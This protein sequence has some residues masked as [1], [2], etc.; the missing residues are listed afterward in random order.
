MSE[1][2]IFSIS[3]TASDLAKKLKQAKCDELLGKTNTKISITILANFSTQYLV[4]SIFTSMVFDGVSPDIY[5]SSFDQ[6]EFEL[7]N[8]NSETYQ[9]NSDYVI[10]ALSSSR[11][12]IERGRVIHELAENIKQLI[13]QYKAKCNGDFIIVLPESMREGFDQTSFFAEYVRAIRTEFREKLQDIAY[14]IDIDPLIMEY[15]FDKWH[16]P[17]FYIT[18]KLSCHPNCY[19]LFG[20][21]ISS[22]ILSLIRRPIRLI[23]VDFD[24]TLWGGVVGDIGWENV[25]L[26]KDSIGFSHLLFQ[27]YLLHLKESGTILATSSKNSI[28]NVKE[29]FDKRKEM[30]LKFED[31]VTHKINWEPK[32]QNIFDI[33]QELNLTSTGVMFIDDS[34]FEREEVKAHFPE[35]VV[36]ELPEHVEHWCEFLSKSGY[37][38]VAKKSNNDLERSDMYLAEKKRKEA[39]SKHGDYADFLRELNLELFPQKVTEKNFDRVFELIHKTNQFNLNARRLTRVELANFASNEEC[40]C[41]CYSLKDK[42]SDYGIISAL[43]V[44]R[45][46]ANWLIHNWIMS[47]RA[48][49]R[50]V[51]NSV[52]DHF[53]ET[54][55]GEGETVLG[56]YVETDKN[57]PVIDL[58]PRIGFHQS[59]A[60]NVYS[61][62]A[63]N[64]KNTK[65]EHIQCISENVLK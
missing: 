19:P 7:N 33:L 64:A 17:K 55:I 4:N 50:G 24:N 28:E 59:P 51:E 21:Y 18:A 34:K 62:T 39:A 16:S 43:I 20:N 57:H 5:E 38:T 52:F 2:F 42:Y 45:Q 23:I 54:A 60:K 61:F 27:S 6:W 65:A 26:D 44:E 47:C 1:K 25:N 12:I 41:F 22:F 32:S 37:L 63:G 40:Y 29:V 53:L 48:M 35:L 36:P 9:R 11:L 30:I 58:L 8:P 56:E 10:L 15:G 13:L 46:K 49:G 31:F 3:S 14:L